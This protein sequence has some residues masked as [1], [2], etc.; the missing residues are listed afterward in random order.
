MIEG[1]KNIINFLGT[2]NALT[3]LIFFISIFIAFY[4][5]YKSFFRLTYATGR[6]CR[7]SNEI[8]DWTNN[9]KEFVTRII[10]FNNGRKTITKNEILKLEL[11]ASNKIIS[12]KTIKG[13][14]NIEIIINSNIVNINFDYIDSSEFFVLEINHSGKL[15]VKGRISET[16]NLLN[17][18]PR[19]WIILNIIFII[20]FFVMM[21]DSLTSLTYANASNI[22]TSVTNF[23][24]LFGIFSVIRFIH[25]ILFIPDSVTS[26]Y[27][28]T[29]DKFAKEFKN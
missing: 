6:I 27:L 10:F 29:K 28:D 15:E 26:K 24:I 22:L 16:G 25:S 18:E 8:G 7:N 19:Y 23:F 4:L 5:H 14:E 17:T 3:I 1:I 20:F 2:G 12:V 11:V 13:S 9:E 21:F